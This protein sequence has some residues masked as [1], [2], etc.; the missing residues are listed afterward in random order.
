MTTIKFV[1]LETGEEIERD[2]NAEELAQWE[3]DNAKAIQQQAADSQ[4]AAD[5]AALLARLG[6][7]ESEAALLLS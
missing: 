4:K 6:I 3:S 2:M 5:K 7:T 1:N